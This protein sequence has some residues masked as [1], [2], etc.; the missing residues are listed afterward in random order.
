MKVDTTKYT[1]TV[2]LMLKIVE[3]LASNNRFDISRK[4]LKNG[5]KDGFVEVTIETMIEILALIA[6]IKSKS[7]RISLIKKLGL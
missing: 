6:T 5:Q 7:L 3:T 2:S 4:L 1:Y